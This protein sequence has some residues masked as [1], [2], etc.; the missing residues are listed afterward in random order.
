M[1]SMNRFGLNSTGHVIS[2]PLSSQKAGGVCF[3][4]VGDAMFEPLFKGCLP[5]LLVVRDLFHC[6]KSN[7]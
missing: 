2:F 6:I 7:L 3:S 5:D 1:F 4:I